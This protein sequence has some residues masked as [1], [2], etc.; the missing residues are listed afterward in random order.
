MGPVPYSTIVSKQT[1][2]IGPICAS[3]NT[4]G[5]VPCMSPRKLWDRS[6]MWSSDTQDWWVGL[7]GKN[8]NEWNGPFHSGR[9]EMA[10]SIPA[11][12]KW[13]ILFRSEWNAPFRSEWNAPFRPEW[14]GSFHS[15]QNEMVTPW[16]QIRN[17]R[18]GQNQK[19]L[20]FK[21][22]LTLTEGGEVWIFQIFPK[23][24]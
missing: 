17:M 4:M 8:Q 16:T 6:H 3:E 24:K 5:P 7:G 18:Q 12:M 19:S 9:N 14:N 10:H 21:C 1:Y 11:R 15:G 20:H 2:G 22:R 23:F 13:P